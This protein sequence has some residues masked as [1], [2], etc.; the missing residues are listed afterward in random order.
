MPLDSL[1]TLDIIEVME[2]FLDKR[3]PPEHLRAQVDLSYRIENQSILIFELRP[4]WDKPTE[5]RES[6]LAKATFIKEKNHWKIFWLLGNL[7]WESYSACPTVKE[8]R[9]FTK[10]V[11]ED[12]HHCFW[13]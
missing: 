9:E 11:D 12:K 1:Q 6:N 2:N 10:I 5:I 4:R 3:R 13:G 7:T 8:L